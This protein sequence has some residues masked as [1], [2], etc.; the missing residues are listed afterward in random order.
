MPK[1]KS[2]SGAKKRFGFTG[3]GKVKYKKCN[4][5]HI[6]T[7]KP[8]KRKRKMRQTGILPA[9]DNNRIARMLPYGVP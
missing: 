7:S 5:S 8:K 6:L 2:N 1:M 9:V 3:T 4:H